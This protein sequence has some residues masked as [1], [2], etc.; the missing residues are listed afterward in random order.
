MRL[1]A[2]PSVRGRVGLTRVFLEERELMTQ[3]DR[4]L[5]PLASTTLQDMS[6]SCG[7][8]FPFGVLSTGASQEGE[9]KRMMS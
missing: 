4:S 8:F 9:M 5:S 7:I 2:L 6:A 3:L 1:Y